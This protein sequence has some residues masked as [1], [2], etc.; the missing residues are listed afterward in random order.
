MNHSVQARA[1]FVAYLS[2]DQNMFTIDS[3]VQ[4]SVESL[5]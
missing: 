2:Y 1:P 5:L 4:K 3:E